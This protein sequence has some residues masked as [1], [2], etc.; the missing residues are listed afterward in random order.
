MNPIDIENNRLPVRDR[1][2]RDPWF[3]TIVDTLLALLRRG[4]YTPTELREALI[5][6]LTIHEWDRPV[7]AREAQLRQQRCDD[8]V[9]R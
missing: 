5:L 8:D 3:R 4:E 2:R 1:Y 6:A 9:L 7:T